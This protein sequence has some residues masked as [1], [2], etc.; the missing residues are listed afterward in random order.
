MLVRRRFPK[1]NQNFEH[2]SREMDQLSGHVTRTQQA[3]EVFELVRKM[4]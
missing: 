4:A 3:I 1:V 2:L